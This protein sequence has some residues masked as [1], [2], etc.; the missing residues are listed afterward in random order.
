M[1]GA[2]TL[3]HGAVVRNSILHREVILEEGVELENCIVLDSVVIRRGAKLRRAIIDR[4][5]V[6]PAGSRI[7]YDRD[8]DGERY[9]VCDSGIVVIP[10]RESQ[11]RPPRN[12]KNR[13]FTS[14]Y[15]IFTA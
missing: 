10:D 5:N 7:G 9:H 2:S 12:V 8:A 15:S 4:Y 1:L 14:D 3:I 13:N 11:R 6:I